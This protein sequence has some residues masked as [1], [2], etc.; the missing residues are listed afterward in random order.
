MG[1]PQ[2]GSRTVVGE[3]FGAT[4]GWSPACPGSFGTISSALT[5]NKLEQQRFS[6]SLTLISDYNSIVKFLALSQGVA[7]V[8]SL[9]LCHGIATSRYLITPKGLGIHPTRVGW[10]QLLDI[11]C[12]SQSAHGQIGPVSK[13]ARTEWSARACRV[14]GLG[15]MGSKGLGLEGTRVRSG[16]EVS[17]RRAAFLALRSNSSLTGPKQGFHPTSGRTVLRRPSDHVA[18]PNICKAISDFVPGDALMSYAFDSQYGPNCDL[19]NSLSPRG[20]HFSQ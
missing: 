8:A 4:S 16:D 17:K 18:R 7:N 14:R 1:E 10:L 20:H 9:G 13:R 6:L 12:S 5:A 15:F 11:S 19:C 2:T 3:S